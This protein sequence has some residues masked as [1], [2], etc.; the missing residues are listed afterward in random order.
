MGSGGEFG[1]EGTADSS[2]FPAPADGFPVPSDGSPVLSDGFVKYCDCSC[3]CSCEETVV[4]KFVDHDI[5]KPEEKIE[6]KIEKIGQTHRTPDPS[7]VVKCGSFP[8]ADT[9]STTIGK[10]QDLS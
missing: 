5:A 4:F 7:V 1:G 8:I 3:C 10:L 9:C 6:K 2:F